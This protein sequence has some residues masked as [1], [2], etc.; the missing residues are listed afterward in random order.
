M[1]AG[2]SAAHSVR[3]APERIGKNRDGDAP[4]R[5]AGAF[6]QIHA[7]ARRTQWAADSPAVTLILLF[8]PWITLAAFHP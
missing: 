6:F 2:E 1:T 8:I 7:G 5:V 4:P 3:S